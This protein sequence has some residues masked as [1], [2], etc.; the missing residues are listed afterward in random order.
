VPL[1]FGYGYLKGRKKKL[2]VDPDKPNPR[3]IEQGYCP[4]D[5][6]SCN[7]EKK[8]LKIRIFTCCGSTKNNA[9]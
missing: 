9:V 4:Q 5:I 7:A 1:I 6:C 3:R 8:K 2:K